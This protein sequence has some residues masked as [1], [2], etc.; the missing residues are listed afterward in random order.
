MNDFKMVDLFSGIGGFSLAGRW[1]DWDTV[2]FV[3][4]DSFCQR[5]LK[6]HWPETPIH[7]DIKTFNGT[8]LTHAVDLVCG[9]FPCQPFSQAGKRKGTADDRHL[10]PEMLRV[11]REIK[12]SWVVG[13][14]VYGLINWDGGVVFDQV[15]L[16]LEHEG[17]K[18]FPYVL[19]ACGVGAPHRRYRVWFVGYSQSARLER[20]DG[21]WVEESNQPAESIT[22]NPNNSG[23]RIGLP[24]HGEWM[25]IN[26][27]R[28]GQSQSEYWKDGSNGIITDTN[29]NGHESGRFGED[30]P[31]QGQ[32]ISEQK[33][34]ERIRN[35]DRGISESGYV[36]DPS[37][38]GLQGGKLNGASNAKRQIRGE[39]PSGSTS[40]LYQ[41]TDWSNFPTQSPICIRDDGF[42]DRLANITFPKWRN[43]SIKSLGNAI[44]PQVAYQIFKAIEQYET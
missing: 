23:A 17:Y 34:R 7:N 36:T 38:T 10:W 29:R 4:R 27:G 33:Q 14:N 8:H 12:P 44:V 28:H 41:I 18:V 2:Q 19:P 22:P 39:Q 32:S 31:T 9:G 30:R 1:M 40:K 26:N 25:E 35:N 11:I 3:E 24:S 15:Q 43:E 6:H 37:D 5:V 42:S 13:E 21:V 16:D 20:Q